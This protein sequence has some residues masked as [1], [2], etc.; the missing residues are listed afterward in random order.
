MKSEG[1]IILEVARFPLKLGAAPAGNAARI[2]PGDTATCS[3]R[4]LPVPRR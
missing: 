1:E 4:A 2:A 3:P